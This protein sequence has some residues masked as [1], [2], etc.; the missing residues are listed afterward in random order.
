MSGN[1]GSE[2]ETLRASRSGG[3]QSGGGAG[4]CPSLCI[5]TLYIADKKRV[6]MYIY[7]YIDV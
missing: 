6:N 5:H 2:E 3:L 7:I 1:A 4:A